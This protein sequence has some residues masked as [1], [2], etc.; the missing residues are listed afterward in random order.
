M[1][2]RVRNEMFVLF[3]IISDPRHKVELALRQAGLHNSDYARQVMANVKPLHPS[4]PD[5]H[6]TV[7]EK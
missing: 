5:Q 7:F 1:L 2:L 4:R 6:S 3:Q